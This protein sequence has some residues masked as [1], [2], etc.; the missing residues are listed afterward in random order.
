MTTRTDKLQIRLEVDG[1]GQV[2]AALTNEAKDVDRLNTSN[3][4]AAR[5]SSGLANAMKA[6]AA[7]ASVRWA[8]RTMVDMERLHAMLRTVTGSTEGAAAAFD[9]LSKMS[10]STPFQLSQIT[11]GFISLKNF[12]MDP[13]NGTLHNIIE[14]SAALGASQETLNGIILAVGQAWGKQ[15]LQGQEILQLINQGVPVWGLLEKAMGKN[16]AELKQMSEKGELGRDAIKGLIEE[17]G[18]MNAGAAAEQMNTLGGALSNLADQATRDIDALDQAGLGGVLTNLV[19]GITAVITPGTQLNVIMRNAIPLISGLMVARYLGPSFER[20]GTAV[21]RFGTS[22]ASA[23][24]RAA[25]MEGVVAALGGPV[26][27]LIGVATAAAT[28]IGLWASNSSDAGAA[29]DDLDQRVQHL[30]QSYKEL[31]RQKL[32]Q[33]LDEVKGRMQKIS[34]QMAEARRDFN[35]DLP[36]AMTDPKRIERLK[37]L[38]Q[39]YSALK[40]KLAELDQQKKKADAAAS[41]PDT[42]K[43]GGKGGSDSGSGGQGPSEFDKRLAKLQDRLDPVAA[44]TR[45]YMQAVADLDKAWAQGKISGEE[46]DRLMMKLATDTDAVTK[47]QQSRQEAMSQ[48]QEVIAATRTQEQQLNIAYRNRQDI[49][50]KALDN[51][52]ISEERYHR[53]SE[54]L[55]QDHQKK[56]SSLA[57]Q[58][59]T[60]RQRF[61]HQSTQ[62]Q[63]SGVLTQLTGLSAGVAAHN[64]KAFELNKAFGIANAIVNTYAGVSRTIAVYPFPLSIAMAAAQLAFGLAQVQQIKNAQYSGATSAASIGGGSATPVTPA[65][66]SG[67]APAT[68]GP[69]PAT[70]EQVQPPQRNVTLLLPKGAVMTA[71]GFAN[72]IAPEINKQIKDGNINLKVEVQ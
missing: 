59:Y 22:L 60:A 45:K 41:Q 8:V 71:E 14:Q 53:V 11:K 9:T 17:M 36:G 40:Q 25:A 10:S 43:S 5:S 31:Q 51:G 16:T 38:G 23:A 66:G 42:G 18:K 49:L 15:K 68:A 13:M 37:K 32:T 56:L 21:L 24:G 69:Q 47:S 54:K 34:E 7:A 62:K 48:L 64:K 27:I 12:G 55:E 61:A 30:T 35:P 2:H 29:T 4:R 57:E 58:G 44:K 39:E 19:H 67:P 26:G 6:V 70:Q 50:Q 28:A 52:L 1:E 65:S 63:V 46:H 20:A 3:E 72:H 33:T